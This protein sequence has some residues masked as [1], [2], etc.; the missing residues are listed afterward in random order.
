MG[1]RIVDWVEHRLEKELGL[2]VHPLGDVYADEADLGAMAPL[3]DE[4]RFQ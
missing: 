3:F 4:I 2:P 1:R